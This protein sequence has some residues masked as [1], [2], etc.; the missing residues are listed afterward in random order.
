MCLSRIRITFCKPDILYTSVWSV[1]IRPYA[2]CNVLLRREQR[3]IAS[4]PA[5]V[6]CKTHSTNKGGWVQAKTKGQKGPV[7]LTTHRSRLGWDC[8]RSSA[9]PVRY[10]AWHMHTS[11]VP[12]AIQGWWPAD[13]WSVDL[14]APRLPRIRSDLEERQ[15][16]VLLLDVIRG[17][18]SG[19]FVAPTRAHGSQME[20]SAVSQKCRSGDECDCFRR[21]SE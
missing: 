21:G 4:L 19:P 9:C 2:L 6:P 17:I 16:C 18:V 7:P 20:S 15:R 1:P 10:T 14:Q 12:A 11:E 8:S 13:L 5:S 3:S